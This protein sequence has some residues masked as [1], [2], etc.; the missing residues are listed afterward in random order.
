MAALLTVAVSP[1]VEALLFMRLH[2]ILFLL[3][4][5]RYDDVHDARAMV[6]GGERVPEE[7]R[8]VRCAVCNVGTLISTCYANYGMR[9]LT[10]NEVVSDMSTM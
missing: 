1:T 7:W 4:V 8:L 2:S 3:R 6:S 5:L 10:P 9:R